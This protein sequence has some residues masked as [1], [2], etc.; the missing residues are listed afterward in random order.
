MT[1]RAKQVSTF[2]LGVLAT[3]SLIGGIG[4][5]FQGTGTND[6]TLN[7]AI[8]VMRSKDWARLGVA[9]VYGHAAVAITELQEIA[10]HPGPAQE[11]A[12]TALQTLARLAQ[13]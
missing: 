11:S 3:A 8:Y 1:T 7:Q 10:S 13:R 2:A 6:L 5:V 4:W 12:I 9:A